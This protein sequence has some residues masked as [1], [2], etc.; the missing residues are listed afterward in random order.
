MNEY[1]LVDVDEHTIEV[2][3]LG[4]QGFEPVATYGEGDTLT[5]PTLPGFSI[6]VDEIF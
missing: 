4:D 6:T 5:S 2:L 1:W 3:Q